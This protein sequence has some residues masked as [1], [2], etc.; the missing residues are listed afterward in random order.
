[1][2]ALPPIAVRQ[3]ILM[4]QVK[5]LDS[6]CHLPNFNDKTAVCCCVHLRVVVKMSEANHVERSISVSSFLLSLAHDVKM[7]HRTLQSA[8]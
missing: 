3:I 8:L 7:G 1:M 4:N 2:H 5:F 6:I